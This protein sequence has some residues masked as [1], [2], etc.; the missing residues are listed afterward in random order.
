MGFFTGGGKNLR[1]N[2]FGGL[3]D[4]NRDGKE[5]LGEQ[6]IAH[7]IIE[8]CEKTDRPTYNRSSNYMGN[9]FLD[10]DDIA[11][12]SWRDYCEDGS[13]FDID[14]N[15]YETEYEYEEALEKAK[16]KYSW[17]DYCEDGS[18]VCIDPKDYETE[19][20]YNEALQEARTEW[21][22][23]C[24]DG[25]EYGLDPEDY[26]TE[27]EYGEALEEAKD[28]VA[29]RDFCEDGSDVCVAP[30]EYE[31]EEEYNEALQEARTAWR[32]FCEDGSEYGL[33]PEDF[34]NEEE[35]DWRE[36]YR[37][38]DTLGLDVN[39]F[40]TQEEYEKAYDVRRREKRQR[41]RERQERERRRQ[42][43]EQ[44]I[45]AE[46]ARTD[47]DI[48]TLCGVVFPHALR[49][50]SYRTEDPTIVIGDD[51]LVPTGDTETI[52]TVVSVGQYMR[53]AAPYP[54]DKTKF[55]IGKVDKEEN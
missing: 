17:R 29:W 11:D 19:Y 33:D 18:D 8:E 28:K 46:T 7:K 52:G 22:D 6:W 4:F 44:R 37:D 23:F 35:Y 51:V 43:E 39:D 42:E 15:D 14:P 9:S 3:F 49:A 31:T 13:E 32:D 34:E 16:E 54:I 5:D 2:P 21:R 27:E 25:S 55:I 36:W 41:E 40:E 1:D 26:E 24:E 10:D 48:Y 47:T 38:D 53:I 50:Y 30:E 45:E 12:T 20:E